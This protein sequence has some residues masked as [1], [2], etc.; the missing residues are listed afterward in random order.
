MLARNF[1]N[2]LFD[3]I[4]AFQLYKM[5]FTL[6]SKALRTKSQYPPR[7]VNPM[8]TPVSHVTNTMDSAIRTI[9][10]EHLLHRLEKVKKNNK[11]IRSAIVMLNA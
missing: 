4:G 3:P 2:C 11:I 5:F 6:I 9:F 1:E 10:I 8:S 7:S